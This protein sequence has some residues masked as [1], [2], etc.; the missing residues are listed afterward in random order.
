M[1]VLLVYCF[2]Y[3]GGCYGLLGLMAALFTFD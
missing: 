3:G 2:V 1:F